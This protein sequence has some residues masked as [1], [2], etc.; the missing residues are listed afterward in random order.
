MKRGV[1]IALTLWA[2][3]LVLSAG[4]Q[5][6]IMT[7]GII[8]TATP[9]G[10]DD[11]DI[12]MVQDPD[13]AHFWTLD[14]MLLDGVVKFRAN[15][16]W[17]LAWGSTDSPLGFGDPT[18]GSPDIPVVGGNYHIFFNSNTGFYY[19]EAISPIGI[20]GDA[21]YFGWDRDMN[22]HPDTADPNAFFLE[23]DL[24]AG[25]AK[26]R[27]ND[28]WDIN[29]G[30]TDFPSGVGVQNGPD[31][32]VPRAGRFF[33]TLD[34]A[35]GAYNFALL[36][37]DSVAI[38]GSATPGGDEPTAM[39][40]DSD[41]P[42][43]WSLGVTLGDGTVQF[44]GFSGGDTVVWG[45]VDFPSGT[46]AIDGGG[47]P[48]PAEKYLIEFD[49]KTLE[50]SFTV[51]PIYETM[52][53]IG[54]ATPN[55]W[56]DPDT[57]MERSAADSSQWTLRIEL[58]DGFA[59]FRANDSWDVNWGAGDFPSGTA[60][61]DGA[62]I[63][64][65]AGEYRVDFNSFTGAYMF[66]E[67]IVFDTV[68][69]IGEA[70]PFGDWDND[71]LMD[72]SPDDENFWTITEITLSE[73]PVKFRANADWTV[74]WGAEDF[75]TGVGTQDGPNIPV[76]A[77][78]YGVSINTATGEYAFGDPGSATREVLN[79]SVILAYPNPVSAILNV[80]ISAL[81]LRGDVELNVYDMSGRLLMSQ[82]QVAREQ[83]QID[84]SDV[85]AGSYTLQI[86]HEDYIIGKRF[87][88]VRE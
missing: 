9:N 84:V 44:M 87:A 60:V 53:I 83:M 66:T 76:T 28:D 15:D 54:D 74:N 8:G 12:D 48:V 5:D 72:K 85:P 40:P 49:S 30:A 82:K 71:V 47:I 25:N 59:K 37:F 6:T 19:F 45:G 36:S 70:T 81:T 34:T 43:G 1:H 62:D 2:M 63:P 55:G 67:V 64:I 18:P 68:G 13:S 75:P 7:V 58:T 14:T 33:V 26:F 21:T 80:D 39:T 32:P 24:T 3:I 88:I 86:L 11:P 35:S 61:R 16:A 65:T 29:W 10:W 17:D 51:V 23:L 27:A 57:D 50:Y 4:A 31:I 22:M 41:D 42:N 46:A 77:G 20:I 52:G 38:R 73:G 79:P 56:N 69:L 78:T